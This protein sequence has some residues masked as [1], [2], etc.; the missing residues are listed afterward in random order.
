LRARA[1][2]VDDE[3]VTSRD[4][5]LLFVV[6]GIASGCARE[7]R[8]GDASSAEDAGS[9]LD[10]A[11]PPDVSTD[12]RAPRDAWTAPDAWTARDA[13]IAP[14][15][16]AASDAWTMPDAGA[17]AD[18]APGSDADLPCPSYAI[19]VQP[20]YARHCAPCH[21]TGTDPHFAS[22]YTVA[23]RTGSRCATT[24]SEAACTI[25]Y[26]QPGG[27]MAARDPLGGF[28]PSELEKIRAWMDCG[29]PP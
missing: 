21:T 25:E 13:W 4:A 11:M 23:S 6:V 12:A 7:V 26:G 19:D 24:I 18:A 20:I 10:A 29:V 22:S 3:G 2:T 15:A 8:G 27:I 1:D 28:S 14:D 16:W 17:M 5:L 9:D